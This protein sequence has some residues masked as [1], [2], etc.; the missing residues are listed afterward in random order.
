MFVV[1]IS[2]VNLHLLYKHQRKFLFVTSNNLSYSYINL[3]LL[4]LHV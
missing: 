2:N 4:E 1:F 3:R